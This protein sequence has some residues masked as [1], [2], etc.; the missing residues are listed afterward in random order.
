MTA[1]V[2]AASAVRPTRPESINKRQEL[3]QRLAGRAELDDPL[4]AYIDLINWIVTHDSRLQSVDRGF[5]ELLEKCA[6]EFSKEV[7][8]RNDSRYLKV[9]IRYAKLLEKP[10][11][12]F[13]Y[14]AKCQIGQ[15]LAMFYE[16][17]AG[18]LEM[19]ERRYQ[20]NEVFK[21]GIEVQARPVKRLQKRYN[22][23]KQRCMLVPIQKKKDE[24]KSPVFPRPRNDLT[25]S[26][27]PA[28]NPLHRP[29]AS[30]IPT[31]PPQTI[32]RRP[33][34]IALQMEHFLK[35]GQEY[36]LE[37]VLAQSR[38]LYNK[39]YPEKV[40]GIQHHRVSEPYY[41][42]TVPLKGSPTLPSPRKRPASPTMTIHSRIATENINDMFNRPLSQG[43]NDSSVSYQSRFPVMTPIT[44]T[45]E[46]LAL[47]T[48]RRNS[49]SS[50]QHDNS[51]SLGKPK[52][53]PQRMFSE[54]FYNPIKE[55]LKN[56]ALMRISPP[57]SSYQDYYRYP[58]T[59]LNKL[60][61]LQRELPRANTVAKPSMALGHLPIIDFT[62]S[63]QLVCVKREI[64]RGG[65]ASVYLVEIATD[66][67]R[68]CALK[69]ERPASLWEFYILSQ[70]RQRAAQQEYG[71]FNNFSVI[72]FRGLHHY[73]DES[74]LILEYSAQGTV[75]DA[76]NVM[77]S[78][79]VNGGIDECVAIFI[80]VELLRFIEQLHQMN[81]IHGDLKPD[82]VM[83]R[84][85]FV[86][87]TEWSSQYNSEGKYGWGQKGIS[88]IDFGRGIDMTLFLPTVKFTADWKTDTQDC[89]Q[90]QR[91]QPWTYEVDY[92]GVAN[93][94]H[95][96]LFG[97]F[98]EVSETP[99]RNPLRSSSSSSSS[100]INPV[101]KLTQALKRYW[102]QDLWTEVF[103]ILLNPQLQVDNTENLPINNVIRNC[104]QKLEAWLEKNGDI[105]GISLKSCLRKIEVELNERRKHLK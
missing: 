31:K 38:Q 98:I 40:S 18:F 100:T 48:L 82:N 96:M 5:F 13:M 62:G 44:E 64:G 73:D 71:S 78:I 2:S 16:E 17:Y 88:I 22:E 30:V 26:L 20:A 84:F 91:G 55:S 81:I 21:R 101:Y 68:L 59:S 36:C 77:K 89:I 50:K 12:V 95:T 37:E 8:Y 56:E 67:S 3:E 72:G 86:N 10:K 70:I 49:A 28:I 1:S 14:L 43:E 33:E 103:N 46:T 93:I 74:Y 11:Q 85:N 32:T 104:R 79:G 15:G 99:S 61:V 58:G 105:T 60:A 94:I 34:I 27:A 45:T 76:V 9:W 90:M 102:Q 24:P 42:T 51:P 80:T 19:H 47:S 54:P 65:Y 23:F 75:L 97:K 52:R 7:M 6:L 4:E 39:R 29:S 63:N 41:T 92:Y 69:V 87:D 83:I 57:I 35:S 53:A 66:S 25:E